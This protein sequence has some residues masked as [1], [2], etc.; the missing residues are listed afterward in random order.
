MTQASTTASTMLVVSNLFVPWGLRQPPRRLGCGSFQT[1]GDFWLSNGR[2]RFPGPWPMSLGSSSC[3]RGLHSPSLYDTVSFAVNAVWLACRMR[4][5]TTCLHR[6]LEYDSPG[7]KPHHNVGSDASRLHIEMIDVG[8]LEQALARC[9]NGEKLKSI[10]V[11]YLFEES[12]LVHTHHL[13][14]VHESKACER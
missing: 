8:E 6:K 1:H 5:L 10:G 14:V 13:N 11:H 3:R 2:I 9:G 7:L 4:P 12:F